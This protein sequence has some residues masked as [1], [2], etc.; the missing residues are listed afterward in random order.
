MH[1]A[2]RRGVKAESE[3]DEGHVSA[4]TRLKQGPGNRL[5]HLHASADAASRHRIDGCA[6]IRSARPPRLISHT[7]IAST[8]KLRSIVLT[9]GCGLRMILRRNLRP[10]SRM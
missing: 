3:L 4:I 10:L 9:E 8:A 1:S 7:W 2:F 5:Y 6:R